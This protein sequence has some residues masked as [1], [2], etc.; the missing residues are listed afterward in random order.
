MID[1]VGQVIGAFWYLIAIE[2]KETCWREAC[3][4][5]A[6]CNLT[7]LLCARGGTGGDNSRFLNT[8]CPLIDPEQ[9]TNSTVFNFGIYTDALK[10]GVVET[11]D[12]PRKLFYCF[13]WGLRNIRFVTHN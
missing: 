10:C 9:I 2:K 8:S 4:K 13:W 5:I 1:F 3:A 12:F 6:G 7:N 11:R